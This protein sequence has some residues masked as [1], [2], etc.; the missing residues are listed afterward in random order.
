MRLQVTQLTID[1]ISHLSC[2]L[3]NPFKMRKY[4]LQ[5]IFKC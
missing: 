2:T 3:G 1:K 4:I 5:I